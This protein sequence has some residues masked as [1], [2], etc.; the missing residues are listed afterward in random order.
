MKSFKLSAEAAL[1]RLKVIVLWLVVMSV[2]TTVAQFN[3]SIIVVDS[4]TPV[5]LKEVVVIGQSLSTK[6]ILQHKLLSGV[7]NYLESMPSVGMVKR[8]A[9]AWEPTINNMN[10]ERINVTID[11]MKI[12]GACT[13]K[14]DPITSYVEVSNLAKAEVSNGQQ[15]SSIGNTIGGS[16][17]LVIDKSEL[18]TD[19]QKLSI[20]SGFET[21]NQ[22]R[23]IGADASV[24]NKRYFFDI[25][26][27]HRKA[28]NYRAGSGEEILYS[29]YSKYNISLNGGVYLSNNSSLSTSLI[30]DRAND[31]GYPA[32][33]MDVSLAEAT[34]A[35]ISYQQKKLGAFTDWE[36]KLYFNSI[37]HIMD[38]SKRPDVPIRMDM[39]GYSDTFGAYS[40]L[41]LF[42]SKHHFSFKWDAFLNNSYA[43]MT[44]YPNNSYE[45]AMFM[46]TWPEVMSLDTGLFIGDTYKLNIGSLQFNARINAHQNTIQSE[47]GL[48]SLQIFFPELSKTQIRMLSSLSMVYQ[49][50]FTNWDHSF[51]LGLGSRAPSVSEAYGFYL[52]NSFDNHD[53]IGNPL[54][55]NESSLEATFSSTYRSNSSKVKLHGSFFHMPNY[56]IGTVD[57]SLSKMTF[58]ADGVKRYENLDYAR[59][60]SLGAEFELKQGE[61]FKTKSSI[62]YHRAIDSEGE[63]LPFIAPI[64]Y[65]FEGQFRYRG[66]Q[67]IASVQG[68]GTQIHYNS[69]YG[70]DQTASYT[71]LNTSLSKR[72][73]VGAN[74]LHIR[75]G[76]ENLLDTY[77]TTYSDWNNIPRMGR[78]LFLNLSYQL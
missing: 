26:A 47:V 15:G 77:Y 75:F 70:E 5:S 68:A 58:G 62:S 67:F 69:Q 37:T 45:K 27:M 6:N 66:Y 51:G 49:L 2:N 9:Y 21:N 65:N 76:A 43:E 14:M 55:E 52:F 36:S 11:G 20:E 41:N 54:L 29:Q 16:M 42:K 44:M 50:R 17:N 18:G 24:A 13:D 48:S 10:T 56:I 33:P 74:Q 59:L 19:I 22:L 72:V 57:S 25:D 60:Y 35:S 40:Q 63:N 31:I 34:I 28:E 30:Y 61:N 32:L 39:P 73:Y 64:E 1:K 38:D 46:L 53:Y 23:I 3:N 78:T 4:L 71:I 12:F 7:E 8:G